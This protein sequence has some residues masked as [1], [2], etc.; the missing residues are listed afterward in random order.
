MNDN[1]QAFPL[2]DARRALAR[3]IGLTAFVYGY[4]LVESIRTC[5]LQTCGGAGEPVRAP[6]NQL[7][8]VT[9][10]STDRDRDV[11]TPA[12]D[13][14]YTTA[15][16]HLADGPQ[17]LKVPS[18]NAHP[19]RYFVLALYDAYTEN[20]ENLGLRNCDPEGETVLLV[21][22][23]GSVP[24]HLQQHRVVH[25]P[26]DLVWLVSRILVGDAEDAAAAR[27]LQ[28]EIRL[29]AAP[30]TGPS[31]APVSVEQWEGEP[32]D[33]MAEAFEQRRP[34]AQVAA[35]FMRHLCF[36]LAEAPGRREDRGMV[37]WLG[38]AGL[39][40]GSSF[41]WE[42]LDAPT[43]E[44]LVE[45][46]TDAVALV[47]TAARSRR[48]R[49]WVL[50]SRAGRYG[51]DYLVRALTAYI[52]LGALATD[53]ALYGAGHFDADAQRLDGR[54]R[55]T[56]RFAPDDMPPAQ[57]FWSVTLYAADR[58]LYGNEIGRHSIGDRTPGL[59]IEADGSLAI[60]FAHERPADAANWLPTPDGPFYLILRLY[61]PRD[62][63]RGWKIPALQAEAA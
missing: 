12:N 38:Q 37:A 32:V 26:T 5:R 52:G 46:F 40:A 15:W 42:A 4:P 2:A 28:A 41:A 36:A 3:S 18:A 51:N 45:G 6:V 60:D 24:G 43:Q 1:I 9:H 61:H 53:E 47:E 14:L 13:L 30:G 58:F 22:P 21:G 56:L 62:D 39:H 55:Y 8:H 48:A 25:C 29:G 63:V 19:G 16:I 27:A 20:F 23:D 59:R 7:Y 31:R 17:L 57:A 50:A 33:A 49:P 11:V 34:L 10:P 44:G 35:S 54:R